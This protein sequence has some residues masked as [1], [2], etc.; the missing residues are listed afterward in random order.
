MMKYI[1]ALASLSVLLVA[2]SPLAACGSQKMTVKFTV[3]GCTFSGPSSIPYGKFTV[4]WNVFDQKHNKTV[5]LII[6]LADGKTIDDLK[7]GNNRET[8][9]WVTILWNTDENAFGPDLNKVRS[10]QHEYDLK[11]IA[12]Y[13]GQPLYFVCGNEEGPTNPLGPIEVTK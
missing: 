7:A 4:N 5:L 8:L 6:T 2:L 1:R 12:G 13:Q 3:N 10:Y 11:T 9:P